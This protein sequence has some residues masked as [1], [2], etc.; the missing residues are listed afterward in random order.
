MKD[1][2]EDPLEKEDITEEYL[3]ELGKETAD[4]YTAIKLYLGDYIDNIV[5]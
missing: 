5:A 2:L 3:D 1:T 4:A